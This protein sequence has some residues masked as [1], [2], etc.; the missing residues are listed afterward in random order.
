MKLL[1]ILAATALSTIVSGPALGEARRTSPQVIQEFEITKS[2]ETKQQT[3]DGISSGSSNGHDTILERVIAMRDDGMELEYDL[4]HDAT[5][6]DR[7]RQWQFPVRIFK[8]AMGPMKLLNADELS[9]RVDRWLKAASWT[10]E[11]CGRWIFTWNAFRIQC[12]PQLVIE[13]IEQFDLRSAQLRAGASYSEPEAL[14][15]AILAETTGADGGI[16]VASMEV[17]P[18]AVRQARAKS[19][20]AVGE[21]MGKA[22]TLEAALRERAKESVSGT[23]SVTFDTDSAGN[24]WRRTKVTRL[25]T[26]KPGGLSETDTAIETVERRLLPGHR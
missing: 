13:T 22:V 21:I 18:D 11:A 10:R 15:P 4:P 17:D 5:A 19:D 24:V 25:E 14:R 6:Q 1:A 2:Y 23:I 16:L 12:D 20:I 7:A 9:A 3:S 8:P 26:K